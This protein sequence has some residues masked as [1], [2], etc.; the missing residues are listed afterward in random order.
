[1]ISAPRMS[2]LYWEPTRGGRVPFGVEGLIGGA[3]M[4]VGHSEQWIECCRAQLARGRD[5]RGITRAAL[6]VALAI[7]GSRDEAMAAANGLIDDAEATDNPLALSW[8]LLTY[9]TA[10]QDSDPDRA[11]HNLRRGLAIAQDTDNRYNETNLAAT[12]CR[13]EVKYGDP[14]A[15]L[16]YFVVAI[17]N[18]LDSGNS[19]AIR[20]PLATLATFLD[21]L[22]RYEPA[23]IIVGY[24]FSPLTASWL[25]ELGP[26]IAHLR[27]VL[28][29]QTYESLAHKGETMTTAA[30]VT[31]AYDQ[32]DQART[33]LNPVSK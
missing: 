11:R 5:T 18:Y 16:D 19:T 1:M 21:R 7:T 14:F 33:E 31:Y 13:F 20:S 25:P 26:T 29:D 9:G 24:G 4:A 3:Y 28:G 17:R 27:G 15:A 2:E 8:A 12:L 30:M 10:F 22:G 32:I 23:A 6:V